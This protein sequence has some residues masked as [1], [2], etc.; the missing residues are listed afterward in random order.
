MFSLLYLISNLN[1]K[2]VLQPLSQSFWKEDD[3][4]R[5]EELARKRQQAIDL[6]NQKIESDDTSIFNSTVAWNYLLC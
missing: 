6:K 4:L 2:T 3:R 5:Q 1:N